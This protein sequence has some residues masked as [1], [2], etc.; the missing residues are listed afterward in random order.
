MR[1]VGAGVPSPP[2]SGCGQVITK[3]TT[4]KAD[5]GPCAGDGIVLG[6]DRVTLDLGGHTIRGSGPGDGTRMGVRLF[7]RHGSTVRNG[8]ISGF[9]AG[10]G[11]IGGNANLVSG[12]TIA[13]NL[14]SPIPTPGGSTSVFGDGI[15]IF[16]ASSNRVENSQLLRNGPYDGVAMLGIGSNNNT[17]KNNVI[18]DSPANPDDHIGGIG[19]I[20][21]AFLGFG[22]PGRGS[23]LVGN[24]ILGNTISGNARVGIS[25]IS[26]TGAVVAN[27]TV[28]N[29][30]L[31]D[32]NG[33][34]PGN[35]IGIQ[36]GGGASP[37]TGDSV[38]N[39]QVHGNGNDGIFVL[40]EGNKI[41]RNNAA[42]NLASDLYD[43][44][45][46][47]NNVWLRNIWGSGGF[48]PDC[49]TKGGSGPAPVAAQKAAASQPVP[50]LDAV[51]NRG[52]AAR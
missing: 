4:L 39:N 5:I 33:F 2:T 13:D 38:S 25:N 10:V 37:L 35:G 46:C 11:I 24:D 17:I 7:D 16:F 28:E 49:V 45:G 44:T 52:G 19:I 20:T 30:G 51:A 22:L 12:L 41:V 42:N 26:N 27:N 3:N 14:G 23:V 21:N 9:D 40:G 6:A 31:D 1:I 32:P 15:A 43:A 36:P 8:T 29:N 48:F 18:R 47:T 34:G 50:S